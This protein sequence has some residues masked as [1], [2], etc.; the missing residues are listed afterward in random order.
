M[1]WQASK[2]QDAV[3]LSGS[4][5]Y[6]WASV[7]WSRKIPLT[8]GNM[9]TLERHRWK[10]FILSWEAG[11]E[12]VTRPQKQVPDHLSPLGKLAIALREGRK[13]RG[14]SFAELSEQTRDYSATTLQRAASGAVVP[15]LEAARAFAH[16]CKLDVDEIDRLWL[17]AYRARK[18]G[19]TTTGEAPRPHLIRDFPDLSAALAELR[20]SHGAPPYRLMEQRARS[21]GLGLSRSTACRISERRQTPASVTSMRAF[22]IGCGLPDRRHTVWLDAW[23]RAQQHTDSVH[24]TIRRDVEELQ[25]EIAGNSKGEVSQERAR[26]LLRKAE[27]DSLER[28]RGFEEPWTVECLRCGATL[29]V[30]L[31]DAVMGRATCADCPE[32]NER[33]REA[34]GELLQNRSGVLSRREMLVLRAA[35]LLDARLRRRQ[36]DVPVLV[37][38]RTAA[39]VLRSATWHRALDAV[40]RRR[41]RREFN[42]EVFLVADYDTRGARGVGPG[43]PR[44]A[45]DAGLVDGIQGKHRDEPE[46]PAEPRHRRPEVPVR[47]LSA[48]HDDI[49]AAWD[50]ESPPPSPTNSGV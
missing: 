15:K 45:M 32:L 38:D 10:I 18:G 19:R 46:L 29:R 26:R 40:L 35:T 25:V 9:E 1:L 39:T 50:N 30:R 5:N 33:V 27:F 2:W 11:C 23:Q 47:A 24:Q 28:Y 12:A 31:S 22:L 4:A 7:G 3:R 43:Q 17:D 16:A 41:L 6:R 14:L 34:W 37:A 44:L 48:V 36:L 20:L 42:L 21:A 8:Q 13:Q 49:A